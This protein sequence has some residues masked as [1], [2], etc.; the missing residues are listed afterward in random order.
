MRKK[1]FLGS[2]I[3]GGLVGHLSLELYG[4]IGFII[5]II[6]VSVG[7]ALINDSIIDYYEQQSKR[8]RGRGV[9]SV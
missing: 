9:R 2:F 4:I 1:I 5:C 7:I 6:L 3:I 8:Q